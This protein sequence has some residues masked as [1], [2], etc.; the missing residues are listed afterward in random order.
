MSKATGRALRLG[1]A[2]A[3]DRVPNLFRISPLF[4]GIHLDKRNSMTRSLRTA[5]PLP[6]MDDPG[7]VILFDGVC[8]LC[9]GF[10]LFVLLRD[11][12]RRFRFAPLQSDLARARLGTDH[13]DS[14]VLLEAGQ[15]LYAETAVVAIL[16]RLQRPW[17]WLGR[18]G[19]WIP[20]PVLA[21]A[22]RFV[23]R[24]RYRIFGR[25]ET[26][27]VPRPEWKGRFLS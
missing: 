7:P 24:L 13:L 8:H 6:V 19:S 3:R 1:L 16:S 23:A 14:V 11:A 22:Y 9:N 12:Q 27:A 21:P 2:G 4:S 10:V 15:V 5:D 26:C 18:L 20:S 17:C 25:D